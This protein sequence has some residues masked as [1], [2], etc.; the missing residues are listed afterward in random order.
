MPIIRPARSGTRTCRKSALDQVG[1]FDESLRSHEDLDLWIRLEE[2]F[3]A[4]EIEKPLV[5]FHETS[6]SLS[7][8]WNRIHAEEDYFTII[9]RALQRRPDRYLKCRT[10]LL[11][12]AHLFWGI[13]YIAGKDFARARVHLWKSFSIFPKLKTLSLWIATLLPG[14]AIGVLLKTLKRL[15]NR[16]RNGGGPPYPESPS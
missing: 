2:A 8:R 12:D 13:Y 4:R 9:E 10:I 6:G 1:Y 5:L 11:A 16:D 15:L 7:K 3:Q 14:K